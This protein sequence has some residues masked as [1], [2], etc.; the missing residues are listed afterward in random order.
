MLSGSLQEQDQSGT[1]GGSDSN[2]I[3]SARVCASRDEAGLFL[4]TVLTLILL[5]TLN[6]TNIRFHHS[7]IE[8][9][10]K[11]FHDHK[12]NELTRKQQ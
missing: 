5:C 12:T 6:P 4:L 9:F 11:F 8:N 3:L 10:I 2:R 1:A 7:H